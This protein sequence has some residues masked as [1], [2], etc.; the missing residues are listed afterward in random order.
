MPAGTVDDIL[1]SDL[2]RSTR[3]DRG[4]ARFERDMC[5][6][7]E[8]PYRHLL[9]ALLGVG[10]AFDE[11]A[12]AALWAKIVAHRKSHGARVGRPVPI[13]AAAIDWL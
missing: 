8:R 2:F 1:E 10:V 13:R 3:T 11:Q 6:Q 12:A 7:T 5:R 4:L 9:R